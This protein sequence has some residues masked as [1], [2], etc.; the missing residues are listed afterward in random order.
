MQY[1]KV[2]FRVTPFKIL[3][4]DS[5]ISS[6]LGGVLPFVIYFWCL[7]PDLNM[8]P[9]EQTCKMISDEIGRK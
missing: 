3:L 7:N 5:S 1:E 6:V 4:S 8:F 9:I 2:K